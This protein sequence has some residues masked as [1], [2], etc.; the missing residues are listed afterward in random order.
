MLKMDSV[1]RLYFEST[2]CINATDPVKVVNAV[3]L[4]VQTD[5]F[6]FEHNS[7]S[8]GMSISQ[9]VRV[10]ASMKGD[11]IKIWTFEAPCAGGF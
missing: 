4:G 9:M 7:L 8:E 6:E 2:I 5:H 1:T 3:L 10:A 11:A